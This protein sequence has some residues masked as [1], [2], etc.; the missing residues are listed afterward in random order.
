MY[1]ITVQLVY[2]TGPICC[3]NELCPLIVHIETITVINKRPHYAQQFNSSHC[4]HQ[5][6]LYASFVTQQLS[7]DFS[8]AS[9]RFCRLTITTHSTYIYIH[10]YSNL[11]VSSEDK[12][13]IVI[14]TQTRCLSHINKPRLSIQ[15]TYNTNI[16]FE[17]TDSNS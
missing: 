12:K 14:I 4:K 2:R 8:L 6:H 7:W 16:Q 1:R 5:R 11:T 15:P 17:S 13:I 3:F 10:L 9:G